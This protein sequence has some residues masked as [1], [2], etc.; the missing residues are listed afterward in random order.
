MNIL[1]S[2]TKA[3]KTRILG[4]AVVVLVGVV[5]YMTTRHIP[6]SVP[7]NAN[8][9]TPPL[10]NGQS[11]SPNGPTANPTPAGRVTTPGTNL[12][13]GTWIT[14]INPTEGFSIK[15]PLNWTSKIPANTTNTV[16]FGQIGKIYLHNS[17]P[18]YAIAVMVE[19]N[20]GSFSPYMLAVQRNH[21]SGKITQLTIN[22]ETAAQLN[23]Y[24]GTK[25][26]LTRNKKL[27]TIITPELGNQDPTKTVLAVYK[28]MIQ[29]F[30]FQ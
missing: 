7:G 18:S 15:Y 28:A 27:Y 2:I 10:E 13:T 3:D 22:G 19:P 6:Q 5:I 26:Y 9:N 21:G 25:T 29:T 23:D 12:N 11:P 24:I 1:S 17:V 14:Y 16:H 8:E 4:A 30:K 20:P